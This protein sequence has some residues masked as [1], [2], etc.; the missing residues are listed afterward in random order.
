MGKTAFLATQWGL[1]TDSRGGRVNGLPGPG[2]P[3]PVPPLLLTVPS[4]GDCD[5]WAQGPGP[6]A[7]HWSPLGRN[8]Q[9]RES[10][11]CGRSPWGHLALCLQLRTRRPG[12]NPTVSHLS[13]GAKTT[14]TLGHLEM[15]GR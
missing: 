11:T 2:L 8:R 9:P 6:G 1:E 14:H 13:S 10:K 12:G 7:L 4:A 15:R 3:S 5:H